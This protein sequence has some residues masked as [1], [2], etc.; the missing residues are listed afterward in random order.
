[1]QPHGSGVIER[2]APLAPNYGEPRFDVQLAIAGDISALWPQARKRESRHAITGLGVGLDQQSSVVPALA[3]SLERYC[4]CAFNEEQFV[5]ASRSDLGSAA[6]D[7]DEIPRCSQQELAHARCPMIAPDNSAPIR[8]VRGLSLTTGRPVYLPVVMVYLYAGFKTRAEKIWFPITTGCAAHFSLEAALLNAICEVI[9]RDALSLAWLQKIPLPQIEV[10]VVPPALALCWERLQRSSHELEHLFFDATTD[11]GIPTVYGLQL[12]RADE[13]ATT[14]VSCCTALDPA[15][16]LAKVIRD[17]TAIRIA[18]RTPRP[19]PDAVDDFNDI[20]HG[21]TYMAH[22]E[23]SSAFE[24]LLNTPNRKPLSAM[25]RICW[26]DE[27]SSLDGVLRLLR[28]R[29]LDVYAIELSTE[30]ALRVGMRV[31]R[32]LIPGLQPV[33]FQYRAR[34]LGHPRVYDAPSRMGH[35][36]N[37][38]AELNHWPQPFC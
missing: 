22:R 30:E 38:E 15:E 16:A 17:M 13:R 10:D 7:L 18:F 26:T 35:A 1:M 24:F 29:S 14:L 25:P 6:L 33:G 36:V 28:D 32:A 11:L 31:V 34:Y 23:R 19:V 27:R 5:F 20:M 2:V 4:T 3:E 12:C 8:W 9:E 37:S 21:A